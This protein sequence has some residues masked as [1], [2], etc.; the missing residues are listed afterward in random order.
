MTDGE[1]SL[2]T[3]SLCSNLD[4]LDDLSG[5]WRCYNPSADAVKKCLPSSQSFCFF[6]CHTHT[7]MVGPPGE[8]NRHGLGEQ[9]ETPATD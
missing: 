5:L 3:C 8:E 1:K 4:T 7:N 9:P 6:L 2:N